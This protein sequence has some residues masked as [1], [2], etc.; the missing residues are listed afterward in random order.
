MNQLEQLQRGLD[1]YIT[2]IRQVSPQTLYLSLLSYARD[3]AARESGLPRYVL[4]VAVY[5]DIKLPGFGIN[6]ESMHWK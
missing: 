3:R 1:R 2:I 4:V 6:H 5:D